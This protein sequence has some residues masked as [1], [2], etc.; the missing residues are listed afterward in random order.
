MSFINIHVIARIFDHTHLINID[1][2]IDG[3]K[4]TRPNFATAKKRGS[5][6]ATL[7]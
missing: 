1:L 5:Q 6:C 7:I 2:I 4:D 3:S